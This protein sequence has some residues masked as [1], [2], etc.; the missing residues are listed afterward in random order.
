MLVAFIPN[1]VL[2]F[3]VFVEGCAD[4]EL[5][6]QILLSVCLN[7]VDIERTSAVDPAVAAFLVYQLTKHFVDRR[8]VINQLLCVS[9]QC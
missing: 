6:E 2:R 5:A 4:A 1:M 8:L 3:G 9:S 7:R